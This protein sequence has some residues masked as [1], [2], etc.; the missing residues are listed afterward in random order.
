MGCYRKK[1]DSCEIT[2]NL[3][4]SLLVIHREALCHSL[5]Q[6]QW[7]GFVFPTQSLLTRPYNF[8]KIE[9]VLYFD[10]KLV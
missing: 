9:A 6:D 2:G 8:K 10:S 3:L 5:V 4:E 1:T 7:D